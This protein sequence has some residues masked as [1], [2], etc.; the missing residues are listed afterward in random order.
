MERRPARLGLAW[1]LAACGGGGAGGETNGEPRATAGRCGRDAQRRETVP[2]GGGGE[3]E[4]MTWA[5]N[6]E[7]V[8]MDY[9]LAYDFN[10]NV[11]R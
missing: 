9:A 10:T 11:A 1:L 3:V 4:K 7:A 5:I 2:A 6:G 8:A